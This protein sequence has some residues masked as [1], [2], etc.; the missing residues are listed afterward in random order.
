[1]NWTRGILA[2]GSAGSGSMK[3]DGARGKSSTLLEGPI[4]AENRLDG[5]VSVNQSRRNIPETVE[6]DMKPMRNHTMNFMAL[7]RLLSRCYQNDV[8]IFPNAVMM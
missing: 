8:G 2:L 3:A 5:I 1:M 4:Q 7:T 6:G